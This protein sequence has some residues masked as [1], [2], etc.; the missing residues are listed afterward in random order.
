[1]ALLDL[2][3]SVIIHEGNYHEFLAPRDP[4][5]QGH[6]GLVPRDYQKHP[7]GSYPWATAVDFPVIPQSE[8]PARI[9]EK[10]SKKSWL[11]DVRMK[12][13]PNNGPIKSRDQ[14]GKG[15]CWAHSGTSAHLLVRAVMNQP[16]ADLSAY[17]V[18]CIIKSY[19]DEGGW[20]AQ[21][22]DFQVANGVATSKTWAQQSMSRSND[23]AATRAEMASHKIIDQWADLAAAQY[24]R[25]L[26]FDQFCTASLIDVPTVDDYNWWS[27]SVCGCRV[28]NGSTMRQRTRMGSGKLAS[29]QEFEA[30]WATNDPVTAGFGRTIWNSW[31]DSWSDN[32]MGILTGSKAI[33]NGGVAPRLVTPS[34]A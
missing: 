19:R 34:G 28:V 12:A 7:M 30:I 3:G 27:H 1:M 18:A 24:D 31:G 9:A 17:S 21:G 32:G 4:N 2:N 6:H 14:N 23:N 22:V 11:A 20:G 15:Y 10:D 33:P 8:W 29:L 13:G 25:N 5:A 16:Y 26:S